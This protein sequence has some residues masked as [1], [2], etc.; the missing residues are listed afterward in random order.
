M[1]ADPMKIALADKSKPLK[2]SQGSG[3]ATCTLNGCP[4]DE[5][6]AGVVTIPG[7]GQA[8]AQC[9]DEHGWQVRW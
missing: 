3:H 4:I 1:T 8:C 2:V 6:T 9:A 7:F 5:H